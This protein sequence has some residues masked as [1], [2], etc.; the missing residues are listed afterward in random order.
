MKSTVSILLSAML[1]PL[2]GFAEASSPVGRVQGST[3]ESGFLSPPDTARP[4][5]WWHWMSGN[6]SKEGI[7]AD[8]E[9]MKKVGLRSATL[10]NAG[11]GIPK[12]PVEFMS[13]EWRALFLHAVQEANRL[14]LK[15]G[16]HNCEGWA[17]SGGIWI[18]PE[19]S[20]Q[21]LTASQIVVTG[22]AQQTIQ[23]PQPAI[24]TK[25]HDAGPAHPF[26]PFYREIAVFALKSTGGDL[27]I[28]MAS[29]TITCSAANAEVAQLVDGNNATAAILPK[30][31]PAAPQSI[32]LE[33]PGPISARSL[34]IQ[35]LSRNQAH[36]GELQVSADGIDYTKVA[37]FQMV[38]NEGA[39]S[40][41]RTSSRFWRIVFKKTGWAA[42]ELRIAEIE[43]SPD[44][45]IQNLGEKAG[46]V[47]SPGSRLLSDAHN[48]G[49]LVEGLPRDSVIDLTDMLSADGSLTWDVPAGHWTILRIGHT[50]TGARNHPVTT[51][52]EHSLEC[53]KLSRSV[54]TTHY[55]A[56]TGQ[57][58]KDVGLLAGETLDHVLIDSWEAKAQNWSEGLI[59]AFKR[60]RGYDPTPFLP[61]TQGFVVQSKAI[62]ERFLWDFRRTVADL[63]A[64]IHFATMTELANADGLELWSE[65]YNGA[66]FDTFQSANRVDVPMTEFWFNRGQLRRGFAKHAASVA[67][68]SGQPIVAAEAFTAQPDSA[69]WQAHPFALKL[70]ADIA[71]ADGVNRMIIHTW[72]HQPWPELRP[73]VTLG[74]FGIQFTGQN[75]WFE[76][77][78]VWTDY[79]TRCQFILQQGHFQA[80]VAIFSE[81]EA[82]NNLGRND[83][84]A[85]EGMPEEYDYDYLNIEVLADARVKDGRITLPS[86]MSYRLLVFKKSNTMT[87]QLARKVRELVKDGALIIGP[88]PQGSPSLT[89][90]PNCDAEVRAIADEVWGDVDGKKVKQHD[91]GK[92]RVLDGMTIAVA[93]KADG[94]APDMQ[95]SKGKLSW[96]HRQIDRADFYFVANSEKKSLATELSLDIE[97]LIP[98]LWHPDTG[99]IETCGVW[100]VENGRTL[101]PLELDPY[102]S[103]FIVFRKPGTPQITDLDGD[104]ATVR[105]TNGM[106]EL[107]ASKNGSFE[108]TTPVGKQSIEVDAL[109]QP[110]TVAGPWNVSFPPKL[111]APE[112][113]VFNQLR[114]LTDHS[115]EG[116]K[117]FSG[118]ATYRSE[119]DVPARMIGKD[120]QVSIDLGQVGVIAELWVN[121]QSAGTLWKPPYTAD[122]SS[123]IQAGKNQLEVRVTNQWRNR[124]IGDAQ[125]PQPL[126]KKPGKNGSGMI[127]W[128]EWLQNGEPKPD[129]GCITFTT[130]RHH[131]KDSELFPAG[132]IGPVQIHCAEVVPIR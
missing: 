31:T 76:Q 17:T 68:A 110:Q 111:G 29:A 41:P 72:P 87:P 34:A 75:T 3:L 20:M 89:G 106:P 70:S 7:T 62:S 22:P 33:F 85:R 125:L 28:E 71:F 116:I 123:F 129:D 30:A 130:Y 118:T 66:I 107:I 101:I 45:R 57:L 77:A 46:Y 54:A 15:L 39:V 32:T 18:S 78:R 16:I 47:R 128:P 44:S 64:D 92:G 60:Y 69:G 37:P 51:M 63:H 98:E 74:Q 19:Q 131:K 58:V 126:F 90:Y 11:L 23:L 21:K 104:G 52:K 97:G 36:S 124:L 95:W 56:F 24:T 73:G 99:K 84:A 119:V 14:G 55:N 132:L 48:A 61:V 117:Y 10:F 108:V 49:P 9:A 50:I 109:P 115:D 79:L 43:L 8:L 42:P 27:P 81:E 2:S 12:G 102:G 82:P 114:S 80:D 65:V 88:K 83:N 121:G 53:D 40:F 59:E 6:I 100:R 67:H 122:V 96:E 94:L 13:D 25:P 127:K 105:I 26:E 93:L 38:V 35:A 1:L 112:S 4:G 5:T 91:F 103:Y 120:K 113:A 86:G